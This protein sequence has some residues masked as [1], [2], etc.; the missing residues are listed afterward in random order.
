MPA[1]G[2]A[3]YRVTEGQRLFV[4]LSTGKREI[5]GDVTSRSENITSPSTRRQR[6]PSGRSREVIEGESNVELTYGVNFPPHDPDWQEMAKLA[7]S[8]TTL[9]FQIVED[10]IV[11]Q[12]RTAADGGATVSIKQDA[13]FAFSSAQ[14]A[15]A[16]GDAIQ[17]GTGNN[18]LNY[19]VRTVTFNDDGDVTGGTV[20]LYGNSSITNAVNDQRFAIV[21]PRAQTVEFSCR[22]VTCPKAGSHDGSPDS[23]VTGDLT[24]TPATL[25]EIPDIVVQNLPPFTQ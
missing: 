1:Q 8:E 23:A 4:T 25:S 22:I 7:G 13:T 9:P 17:V 16:P 18:I 20:H 6:Y 24:I 10:E 14:E 2:K 19:L 5:P 12:Q 11:G 3:I 15:V 21:S